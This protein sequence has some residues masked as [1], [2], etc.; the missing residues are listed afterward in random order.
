MFALNKDYYVNY[1]KICLLRLLFSH[2]VNH[3]ES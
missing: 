3:V 1:L 2:C